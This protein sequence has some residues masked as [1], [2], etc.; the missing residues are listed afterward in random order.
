MNILQTEK[1]NA[2]THGAIVPV[3]AAGTVF[4]MKTASTNIS[5]KIILLIFGIS[6][7]VLFTASFLYHAK[8]KYENERSVWRKLDRSAI[9]ILIAG[10]YTPLCFLYLDGTLMWVILAGQWLCVLLGFYF[11]F[12]INAPRKISTLIYLSMGLIPLASIIKSMPSSV[13]ILFIAGTISYAAGAAIYAFKKP[14]LSPHI[15]FHEL[16]HIFVMLGALFYF[17]MITNGVNIYIKQ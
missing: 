8:K 6:A 3:M 14:N 15:G 10:T 5:L 4:L 9:F 7:I 16:F 13:F 11:C 1:V 2:V 12:F 17:L